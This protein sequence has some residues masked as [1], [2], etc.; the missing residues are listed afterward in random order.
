MVKICDDIA[1]LIRIS[2]NI[3][4]VPL[5]YGSEDRQVKSLTSDSTIRLLMQGIYGSLRSKYMMAVIVGSCFYHAVVELHSSIPDEYKLWTIEGFF[6]RQ[7]ELTEDKCKY[8][9]LTFN[10][11]LYAIDAD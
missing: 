8:Y 4:P 7:M 2:T 9:A 3:Y 6:I 1:C 11:T 5:R 10:N